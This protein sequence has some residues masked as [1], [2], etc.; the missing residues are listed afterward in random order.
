M[1]DSPD[2]AE[3]RRL[4]S[5]IV[6]AVKM[7]SIARNTREPDGDMLFALA[8]RSVAELRQIAAEAGIRV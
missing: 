3:K 4:I 2:I 1:S 5:L 7:H 8:F 6:Q